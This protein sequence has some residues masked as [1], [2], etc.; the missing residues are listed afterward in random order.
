M[1]SISKLEENSD[2]LK[3]IWDD[4]EESKFNYLWLRDNCPS[5]H[6]KDSRHRMFNILN[7][8][9]D[10]RPKNYNVNNKGSLEIEW[11]EGDHKSSYDPLW[12]RENCYTIKNKITYVSPYKLWDNSL[13]NNL[14]SIEIDH[15][16]I[17]NSEDGL[18]KWL[19]LLHYTGI[20]IVKNAPTEQ[21]SAFKVLN[22]ISHT[23]ETFFKTPF[24][25]INIPKPNNSA[26][27]AHALRNHMDL[28]WFENPPGYQFLH[29]L[30]NSA[31]GGNS[32]AVDA[33]AVADYLRKNE[34]DV[35]DVLVNTP[36]KF[37]DKDYTQEAIRSF[38]GPA[39]SLTKDGDFNDIRY[40]IATL[41]TL[42][43]HPDKMDSVYRAHHRF[44]NL[45]HDE[46]YQINFRLEPGDVFSF[47]NRR[48]LHGRTEFDPNSGHRHLQGYYMDRDEIIGR[49]SYLKK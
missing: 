28:P 39:I 47:N 30:I 13:Q 24:E 42:D 10:I 22:R 35:F 9:T 36:L 4:G 37:R 33:F 40:S 23:R 18:V 5:A 25:V 14:K 29:C 8:S 12:L 19:E 41:D 2:H 27:T 17:I 15:D 32:S 21:N 38:Y 49:L 1:S 31:K 26:Y 48:L 16:E 34:K 3:V 44:G 43:C 6:D 46:K 45:L 11:S 7:V 20:A